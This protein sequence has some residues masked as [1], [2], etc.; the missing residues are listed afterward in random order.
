[1]GES[2]ELI[3][4]ASDVDDA[5]KHFFKSDLE[6]LLVRRAWGVEDGLVVFVKELNADEIF[7]MVGIFA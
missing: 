3:A 5:L 2:E 6:D 7:Q 1:V 4:V